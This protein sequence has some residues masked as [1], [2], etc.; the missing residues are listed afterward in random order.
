MWSLSDNTIA[1]IT[2]TTNI[3]KNITY[4]VIIYR[5]AY[6]IWGSWVKILT[7]RIQAIIKY[8]LDS[9]SKV[10]QSEFSLSSYVSGHIHCAFNYNFPPKTMNILSIN[11]QTKLCF[12][13]LELWIV[14]KDTGGILQWAASLFSRSIWWIVQSSSI[15]FLILTPGTTVA[16]CLAVSV[17]ELMSA[18]LKIIQ[19]YVLRP[20]TAKK[21]KRINLIWQHKS[22]K[23]F[24]L[25]L[26]KG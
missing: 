15:Y 26:S 3:I 17:M 7:W 9:F 10:S 1:Y 6:T 24:H 23:D 19:K 13:I 22:Y 4:T 8:E 11:Y 25:V 16:I 5:T 2:L 18:I 20:V 14:Q 21:K 12:S